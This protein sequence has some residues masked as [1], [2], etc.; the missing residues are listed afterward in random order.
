MPA[1]RSVWP[2]EETAA[3]SEGRCRD[4][5]RQRD[6][7]TRGTHWDPLRKR[8]SE[9]AQ[10]FAFAREEIE[11]AAVNGI[12][13]GCRIGD[14]GIEWRLLHGQGPSRQGFE[15]ERYAFGRRPGSLEVSIA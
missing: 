4:K 6:E 15:P 7:A 1:I 5:A 8:W 13:V 14:I 10:A 11:L 9:I 2:A 12:E 3:K